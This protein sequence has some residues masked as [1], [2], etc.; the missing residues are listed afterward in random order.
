MNELNDILL[1][2]GSLYVMLNII[3][4]LVQNIVDWG[5]AH[6]IH[7]IKCNA[8]KKRRTSEIWSEREAIE[9]GISKKIENW[10]KEKLEIQSELKRLEDENSTLKGKLQT[11][12]VMKRVVDNADS[13]Y[14]AIIREIDIKAQESISNITE[15]T[16]KLYNEDLRNFQILLMDM[17]AVINKD[18]SPVYAEI[19]ER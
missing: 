15:S 12:D 18:A 13:S 11:E 3:F 9:S 16:K 8:D 5:I 7:Q 2:A 17:K 19:K 14:S 1:Y 4:P 10:E 6:S